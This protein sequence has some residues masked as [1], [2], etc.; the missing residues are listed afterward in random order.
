MNSFNDLFKSTGRVPNGT[1]T[2]A[3]GMNIFVSHRFDP[4]EKA[5]AWGLT[6]LLCACLLYTSDA[7]DE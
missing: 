1:I 6:D 2:Q 5:R 4:D 3:V 7:A